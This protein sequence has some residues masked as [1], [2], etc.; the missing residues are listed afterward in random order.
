MNVRIDKSFEKDSNKVKDKSILKK[1]V[2]CIEKVRKCSQISEITNLKKLQGSNNCYRI[3][4]GD[5][6]A[7]VMISGNTVTFIRF[8]HR[9]EIYRTFP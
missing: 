2:S 9:K 8:L 5:Y 3:R 6:R 7:G 4:I 1:I